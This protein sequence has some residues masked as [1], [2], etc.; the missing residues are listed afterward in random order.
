VAVD[1]EELGMS[2][3]DTNL[4]ASNEWG[5]ESLQTVHE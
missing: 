3:E 4:E 1:L 2:E 5:L